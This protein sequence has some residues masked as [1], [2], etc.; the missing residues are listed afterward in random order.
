[1]ALKRPGH[2]TKSRKVSG[3][4]RMLTMQEAMEYLSN[5]GVPC[6]SRATF[7]RILTD[8]DVQ[9]INVNPNGKNA[10]RRFPPESLNEILESKGILP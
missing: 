5:K 4:E 7:Y 2:T 3:T 8:F 6:K 10:V 1:M 9:Y